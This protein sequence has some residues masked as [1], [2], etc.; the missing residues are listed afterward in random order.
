MSNNIQILSPFGPKIGKLKIPIKLISTINKKVDQIAKD[1]NLSKKFDYS[2]NLVGQVSQEIELPKIFIEKSLKNYLFLAVKNFI[3]KTLNKNI[4]KFKIN[5][6]WVVRQFE[7]EYNPI[8]FHDGHISG[9]G[10]LKVP[11][12]MGQSKKYK[13][14]ELKTHGTIDFIH[15][16]RNLLSN[17]IY[18]HKPKVGDMILFPN[19]LMHTAYPF[20]SFEE[21]RSFSFNAEIDEKIANVFKHG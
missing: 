7:N 20:K 6:I 8:H 4:T 5:N 1:K 10:Y 18:N 19:Y 14:H 2:Q 17:S 15:G 9:V 12:S 21:R 13:T 11:K 3:K 16:S